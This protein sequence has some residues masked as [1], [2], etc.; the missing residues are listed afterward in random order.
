MLDTMGTR[1]V[2]CFK[3]Q[4]DDGDDDADESGVEYF[5]LYFFFSALRVSVEEEQ[6]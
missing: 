2:F 1:C 4:D 3:L 6:E 5:L